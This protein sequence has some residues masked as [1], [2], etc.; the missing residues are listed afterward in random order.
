MNAFADGV[1]FGPQ[2]VGHI[3]VNDDYDRLR[4]VVFSGEE[5]TTSQRNSHHFKIVASN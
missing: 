4:R 5:S 2:L 1:L 3:F